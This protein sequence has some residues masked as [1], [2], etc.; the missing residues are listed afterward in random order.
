MDQHE[1]SRPTIDHASRDD[2][3]AVTELWVRLARE[4]R[5]HDSYVRAEANRETMRETLAA[6]Q[7]TDGLLV[8]RAGGR[9]VGFASVSLE[10]GSLELEATRGLLSNVYVV[11]AYRGRGVGTALLEAAEAEL[12]DRGAEVV[13]LEVMA[14]NEAARRFYDRHGYDAYRVGME[15]SLADDHSK[16]DTHS[17]EDS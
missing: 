12:A 2:L 3:E 15:R 14:R 16:N 8:A 17:K 9:I 11:P 13:I 5:E 10:R 6:H 1:N 7:V 4:Q